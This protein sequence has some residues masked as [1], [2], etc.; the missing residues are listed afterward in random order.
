MERKIRYE[1][2]NE[3]EH[4]ASKQSLRLAQ[5]ITHRALRDAN[6]NGVKR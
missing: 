5:C 1:S 2:K 3:F 6:F 4:H